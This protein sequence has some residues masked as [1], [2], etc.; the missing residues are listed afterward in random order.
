M[1]LTLLAV[2]FWIGIWWVAA[3]KIGKEWILPTPLS[4]FESLCIAAR[5]GTLFLRAGKSLVG[6]AAG[7]I[8]GTATGVV[9]AVLTAKSRILHVLFSPLLTVVRA[10]PVASF[11]LI[12]WVF[13]A[14]SSVPA[15]SVWLIV[16][17]IVWANCETGILGIDRRLNEMTRV[18]C[19]S[20][21]KKLFYLYAPS[22][23]PYF[24][25]AALTAMGMA[26]KAGVAAEVLCTPDGTVGQMIWYAKRDIQ[27]ADLFAWTALV[28][29]VCFLLEKF[30][31]FLLSLPLRKHSKR[32]SD[33]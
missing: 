27:T 3:L 2:T 17:P 32:K 10:T 18:Y 8:F 26:W 13:F 5:E 29:V 33:D 12:L 22:V 16:L 23:F 9:L 11:I 25:T 20:P 19:F 31:S 21:V 24:K 30:L 1:L 14:R 4:V 7:Y 6:I 15:I 28:V